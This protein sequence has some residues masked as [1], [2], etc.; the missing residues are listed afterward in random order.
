VR[1]LTAAGMSTRAIAPVVGVSNKT[2]HQDLKVLPEVTPEPQPQWQS[3][4]SVLAQTPT[5]GA[6]AAPSEETAQADR[7]AVATPPRP[8]VQGLDGKTY[9]RPEPQAPKRRPLAD[10]FRD[11]S[12][13]LSK[14]V[15]RAENLVGDDRFPK[16]KGEVTRYAHDLA[17]AIDALQR[18]ADQ[19]S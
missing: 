18:V 7:P 1:E 3:A 8:P 6:D 16:N 15:A 19:M 10:G 5:G 9:T 12:L 11:L 13:D 14:L 17:R 2:V 4:T